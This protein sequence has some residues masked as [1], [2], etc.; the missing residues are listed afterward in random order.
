M[1]ESQLKPDLMSYNAVL[2]AIYHQDA[3]YT[4]FLQALQANFYEHL[5]L[6]YV[7]RS[8]QHG[9]LDLIISGVQLRTLVYEVIMHPTLKQTWAFLNLPGHS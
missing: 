3:G 5:P 7:R 2:D 8:G 9:N 1:P 4:L 6:G